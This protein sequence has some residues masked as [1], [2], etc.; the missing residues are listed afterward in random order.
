MENFYHWSDSKIKQDPIYRCVDDLI[1]ME[2]LQSLED[3]NTTSRY[4]MSD[5][6]N[7]DYAQEKLLNFF[8]RKESSNK[9]KIFVSLMSHL[10]LPEKLEE[11]VLEGRQESLEQRQKL[12]AAF[13]VTRESFLSVI[14]DLEQSSFRYSILNPELIEESFQPHLDFLNLKILIRRSDFELVSASLLDRGFSPLKRIENENKRLDQSFKFFHP[15]GYRVTLYFYIN[16]TFSENGTYENV[17]KINLLSKVLDFKLKTISFEELLI[18]RLSESFNLRNRLWPARV[19]S[20]VAWGENRNLIISSKTLASLIM[21]NQEEI[22]VGQ[23]LLYMSR[24]FKRYLIRDALDF[25]DGRVSSYFKNMSLLFVDW[26]VM[27]CRFTLRSRIV[28]IKKLNPSLSFFALVLES[29]FNPYFKFSYYFDLEDRSFFAKKFSIK[30]KDYR[31][32]IEE[33]YF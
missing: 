22:S 1:F 9:K 6:V 20:L 4:L 14:M 5:F 25:D 27:R 26:R 19:L 21:K 29:F 31:G 2:I 33:C 28:N 7:L 3:K 16:N 11:S 10:I 13:Y 32:L 12:N 17:Q 8:K 24:Y 18:F 30:N 15:N 23:T